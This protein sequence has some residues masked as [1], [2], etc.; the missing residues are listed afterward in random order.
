MWIRVALDENAVHYSSRPEYTYVE[1]EN[2]QEFFFDDD[3]AK[4]LENDGFLTEMWSKLDAFFDWGDCDYFS[5]SK[6]LEFKQWLENRLKRPSDVQLKQVYE[7]MLDLTNLAIQHNT[8][9]SFDF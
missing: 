8:G 1:G 5:P 2:T 4:I 6:C 3:I 7:A 9:M